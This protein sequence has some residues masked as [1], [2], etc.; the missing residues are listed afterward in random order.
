[1]LGATR[2]LREGR[3]L[4]IQVLCVWCWEGLRTD[5]GLTLSLLETPC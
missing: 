2:P 3:Y 1:M 4:L 5:D